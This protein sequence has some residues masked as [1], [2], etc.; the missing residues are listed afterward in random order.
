MTSRFRKPPYD[1]GRPDFP[2][3]V[4]TLIY[5]RSPFH[6]AGSLSVD[7]HSPLCPMVYFQGCSHS[8]PRPYIVRVLMKLSGAQSHFAR[9]RHYLSRRHVLRPVSR[10]Y[11]AFIARTGS[12]ADP[13]PSL[14]LRYNLGR[15]VFAGCCQPLLG[16]G[17]SRR[18]LC[19]SFPTCLDPYPGCSCGAR[20]RY[21]PQDNGLPNVR[22]WSARSLSQ[23]WHYPYSNFST[24]LF[25]RLQSFA[26]VQARGF[27]RHPDCSYR[28]GSLSRFRMNALRVRWV[29]HR[30]RSGPHSD[31]LKP[32][33][34]P[35]NPLGSHGFYFRAYLGSL[36]PQTADMLTVR[37]RAT[38]GRGTF[39][40]Q[41]SQPCRLLP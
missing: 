13:N 16:V 30:F 28:R 6:K 20:T 32:F 31:S 2:D 41:D 39:T 21:F 38:D 37:F 36:P 26:N 4:L 29:F 11:P 10:H 12:C 35:S 24:E 19:E 40:L 3:P 18:Y 5:L 34:V 8:I 9:L 14:R 1:P 17:P 27:A 23:S 25:T 22:I 33:L 7:S 15:W